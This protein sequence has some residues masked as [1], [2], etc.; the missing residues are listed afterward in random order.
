MQNARWHPFAADANLVP[1]IMAHRRLGQGNC[2]WLAGVAQFQRIG[3]PHFAWRIGPDGPHFLTVI[4]L[5]NFGH[6]LFAIV[7]TA[8]V[9]LSAYAALKWLIVR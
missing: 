6:G 3:R 8:A 9:V 4:V 5:K 2:K 1:P 7:V